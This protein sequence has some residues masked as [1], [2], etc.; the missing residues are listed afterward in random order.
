MN[1]TPF[2]ISR[3][4]GRSNQQV[5]LDHVK[6]GQP[7]TVYTYDDL[8][9]ILNEDSERHFEIEDVRQV[10]TQATPRLLKE[11]ARALHNIRGIGYRLAP[12]S[13]HN[14][15]ANIHRRRSN[16]QLKRAKD[17]LQH[18]RWDEMSENQRMAH[19]GTLIL[20]SALYENQSAF[21]R[22]LRKIEDAI[23]APQ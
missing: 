6:N 17:L 7:G 15:L 13:D 19:E 2:Q 21:D 14:A 11:Q 9:A 12:G 1:A 4:D 16:N 22:R 8:A 5:L 10:V 20:V 3:A 18:V 23:K